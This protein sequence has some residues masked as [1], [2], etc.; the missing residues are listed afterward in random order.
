MPQQ[1][2]LALYEIPVLYVDDTSDSH[3][4]ELI[5]AHINRSTEK[6]WRA[7]RK[8][9]PAH[10]GP[11][12]ARCDKCIFKLDFFPFFPQA[13]YALLDRR[14]FVYLVDIHA[15]DVSLNNWDDKAYGA[16]ANQFK[17]RLTQL[18]PK[19]AQG[20]LIDGQN[21]IIPAIAKLRHRLHPYVVWWSAAYDP[22]DALDIGGNISHIARKDK[23]LDGVLASAVNWLKLQMLDGLTVPLPVHSFQ[24]P[25]I[26]PNLLEYPIYIDFKHPQQPSV[27]ITT[28]VEITNVAGEQIAQAVPTTLGPT[29]TRKIQ[30]SLDRGLMLRYLMRGGRTPKGVEFKPNSYGS[31]LFELSTKE[32]RVEAQREAS[33][34]TLKVVRELLEQKVERGSKFAFWNWH[35]GIYALSSVELAWRYLYHAVVQ[36]YLHSRSQGERLEEFAEKAL[37]FDAEFLTEFNALQK[38]KQF[39]ERAAIL[40]DD[41]LGARCGDLELLW[42]PSVISTAIDME[43]TTSEMSEGLK[44]LRLKPIEIIDRMMKEVK[45]DEKFRR[46][47]FFR[48]SGVTDAFYGLLRTI[49]EIEKGMKERRELRMSIFRLYADGRSLHDQC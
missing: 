14:Y 31:H 23:D 48:G 25:S 19:I 5:D 47:T 27:R 29:Y 4:K 43:T 28:G 49:F 10:D 8:L 32:E 30:A 18:F 39:S 26:D 21:H 22:K 17:D 45:R 46:V 24:I 33:Y 44:G 12:D 9:C 41:E 13:L 7:A 38:A 15:E 34:P 42:M 6:F 16:E 37:S 40:G 1:S 2:P 3:S 36:L 11:D 20:T 35:G